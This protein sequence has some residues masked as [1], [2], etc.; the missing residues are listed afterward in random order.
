MNKNK[1]VTLSRLIVII[2]VLIALGLVL[3]AVAFAGDEVKTVRVGYYE[4]EVFQ[5]GAGDGSVKTGYAYE[6][7]WKLSEYTGWR[8]EYVYGGFGDLYQ[9]L[10]D[11]EIDLFAGLAWKEDRDTLTIL[12]CLK[13]LIMAV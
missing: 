10:L 7:Y 3:P 1:R 12:S 11:G 13:L 2:F 5:E 8:Y 9:M 6:Y 4:N